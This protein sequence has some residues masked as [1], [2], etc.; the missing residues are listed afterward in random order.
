MKMGICVLVALCEKIDGTR[1]G[2]ICQLGRVKRCEPNDFSVTNCVVFPDKKEPA[3]IARIKTPL[4][5]EYM[6][7]GKVALVIEIE[8]KK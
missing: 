4:A 8:C 5:S 2:H 7:T 1:S 6:I 3:L